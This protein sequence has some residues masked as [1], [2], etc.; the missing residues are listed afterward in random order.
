MVDA[1]GGRPLIEMGSRRT[2]EEAAV[3]A[4]R[5]AYLA[6]LRHHLEPGGR[7]P[8]RRPDGRHRR[9]RLHAAARHRGRRLPGPGRRARA[10]HHAAGRHLR[11]RRGHPHRGR[12]GR[13][14]PRRGPDRL[15]RPGVLA[16][17]ARAA[18]RRARRDETRIVLSGDLDEYGSPRWPRRRSTP[19]GSAPRWSPARAPD[20]RLGLQA[21][22]GRRP[23]GRQALGGQATHGGR[24][25]A[26][27][28]H[29]ATGTATEE[30]VRAAG[31]P[32]H[33]GR[34]PRR[35]RFRSCASG[36]AARPTAPSTESRD[37]LRARADDLP[38][39]GPDAVPGRARDPDRPRGSR[40]D[41]TTTTT[42][43]ALLVVDVQND[44][45]DP[46]GGL[47]VRGG[48]EVVA[49]IS[50]EV[51][52]AQ[53][54]GAPSSTPRTGTP[55]RR[56]TSRRTAASG[57]CTASATRGA[58]SCTPTCRCTDRWCARGLRRGRL[59]RLLGARPGHR[60]SAAPTQL[61][62]LLDTRRAGGSSSPA[63]PATTASRRPRSTA[64][65]S[66]TRS[67]CRWRLTRFVELAPGDADDAIAE[68]RAAG[69]TL[70]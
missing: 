22:R 39:A 13:P 54:A 62:S 60:R 27:R 38:W 7:P 57:R 11:H 68:M 1:A 50:V 35:C 21:G 3:A 47:Y 4:A 16:H 44:F 17:Q 8:A 51:A 18:A 12:G 24:K 52:A 2:H 64:S 42:H 46:A 31:R 48:E 59:L 34:R 45:A 23:A 30:V 32:G 65:G 37:H 33:A 41:L 14:G 53:D 9:A 66:A 25:T 29:R 49:P 6:G 5:A 20:R 26:V 61:Q 36:E 15:R 67:W 43:A 56:R 19:T 10:G 63:S 69:V 40:R 70:S 58:P 55:S 28:R